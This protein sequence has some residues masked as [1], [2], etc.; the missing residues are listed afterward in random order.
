MAPAVAARARG[1]VPRPSFAKIASI[2]S[3]CSWWLSPVTCSAHSLWRS[4]SVAR[5]RLGLEHCAA[6]G[7]RAGRLRR[8]GL[9]PA[10]SATPATSKADS[11]AS[12]SVVAAETPA[13]PSAA[14]AANILRAHSARPKRAARWSGV[15]P[16]AELGGRAASGARSSST[17]AM[18]L[19]ASP[20]AGRCIARCPFG[21]R[22][23]ASRAAASRAAR[24]R[25]GERRR[26]VQ[27][28]EAVLVL[29]V[30]GVA[31]GAERRR[32][33]DVLRAHRRVQ[34]GPLHRP[35]V[36]RRPR[37]RERHLG[38]RE[39]RVDGEEGRPGG[40]VFSR[41]RRRR[42]AASGPPRARALMLG[43]PASGAR[44]AL[45]RR[46]GVGHGLGGGGEGCCG[47]RHGSKFAR[48]ALR[49][50]E[51]RRLIG[52]TKPQLELGVSRLA[53][54]RRRSFAAPRGARICGHHAAASARFS[55]RNGRGR[56]ASR[57]IVRR[58]RRQRQRRRGGAAGG[59]GPRPTTASRRSSRPTRT[60]RRRRRSGRRRPTPR[61]RRSGSA[62]RPTRWRRWASA[63]RTER[64]SAP[65]SPTE[66]GSTARAG[67]RTSSTTTA[68]RWRWRRRRTT[69]TTTRSTATRRSRRAGRTTSR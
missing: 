58:P 56:A 39:A 46:L 15:S 1:R 52:S 27:R 48:S 64:R 18:L 54:V 24:H 63:W 7:E 22:R 60:R 69:P 31:V 53:I 17:V 4:T 55:S 2:R 38:R 41:A 42:A 6:G 68:T 19:I 50:A 61:S 25:A 34:L 8:S 29:D 32:A 16:V 9:P 28:R 59:A 11:K 10:A 67:A 51:K 37:H 47:L 33:R 13:A 5:V 23:R 62:S 45:L 3:G 26:V 21:G 35:R 36:R 12:L 14:A 30:D 40:G 44:A 65:F 20:S 49:R 43:L 66:A 57:A